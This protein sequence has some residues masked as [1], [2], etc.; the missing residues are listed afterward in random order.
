MRWLP[1]F[2]LL[3]LP[4]SAT[5]A[6]WAVGDTS[7]PEHDSLAK[8]IDA[9]I[10]KQAP[11]APGLKPGPELRLLVTCTDGGC[12]PEIVSTTLEGDDLEQTLAWTRRWILPVTTPGLAMGVRVWWEKPRRGEK[13][14]KL[15][16]DQ[17]PTRPPPGLRWSVGFA[18]EA[19]G[20]L[21]LDEVLR[22]ERLVFSSAAKVC[23]AEVE[24]LPA[25][26]GS[27]TLWH[28]EIAESG[29]TQAIPQDQYV[30]PPDE[31]KAAAKKAGAAAGGA[32]A[33]L[34]IEAPEGA[35]AVPA[36]EEVAGPEPRELTELETC[37][38]FK[39]TTARWK[40]TGATSVDRL[41]VTVLP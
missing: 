26:W 5:A 30:P 29:S 39:L 17:Q 14:E 38:A 35:P 8:A 16:G 9:A 24:A 34:G 21:P 11:R 4:T 28:L 19:E 22:A 2:L 31:K 32:A 36:D 23:A 3:A 20:G 1:L 6:R 15:K 27:T 25:R 18:P 7:L 13:K 12:S 40:G 37:I 33:A 41:P 10:T